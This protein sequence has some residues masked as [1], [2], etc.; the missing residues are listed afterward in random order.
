[1][2][3]DGGREGIAAAAAAAAGAGGDLEPPPGAWRSRRRC[4]PDGMPV[5]ASPAAIVDDLPAAAPA[6]VRQP[7]ATLG[8]LR[9]ARRDQSGGATPLPGCQTQSWHARARYAALALAP[10]PPAHAG[11]RAPIGACWGPPGAA[12]GAPGAAVR[13]LRGG[14]RA[15]GTVLKKQKTKKRAGATAKSAPCHPLVARDDGCHL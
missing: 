3:R 6:A 12:P 9:R 7:G 4:G 14:Q 1:M 11:A 2:R 8:G 13:A 10:A 15:R 5:P